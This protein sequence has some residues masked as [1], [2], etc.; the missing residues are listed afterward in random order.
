MSILCNQYT[1]FQCG[2][3][4]THVMLGTYNYGLV[5]LSYVI[6]VIGSYVALDLISSMRNESNFVFK[7]FWLIGGAL[8]MGAAIWSMHFVGMLAFMTEMKMSYGYFWTILSLFAAVVG[9]GI[10]FYMLQAKHSK[11]YFGLG[12]I[13]IGVSIV[14]MHYMGMEAMETKGSIEIFYY[15]G[16]FFLSI[17]IAIIASMGAIF[18]ALISSKGTINKRFLLKIISAIIMGIAICGMHYTGM[19]A[20]I[21]TVEQEM[22]HI[23]NNI[24]PQLLAFY[25][26]ALMSF[27]IIISLIISTQ[28]QLRLNELE[29]KKKSDY[30][31]QLKLQ[32][33]MVMQF[34][35]GAAHEINNPL[36]FILSNIGI[37]QK[38]LDIILQLQ[39]FY[40]DLIEEIKK[41]SYSF[42]SFQGIIEKI[43]AFYKSNKTAAMMH[44]SKSLM[45]ESIEGL[46]RIKDIVKNLNSFSS[47]K[48]ELKEPVEIN[49]IIGSAIDSVCEKLDNQFIVT[50]KLSSLPPFLAYPNQLKILFINLFTNAYEALEKDGEITIISFATPSEIIIKIIDNGVGISP[51]TLPKIFIPFFTTKPIGK[52][53]GLGLATVF[54]IIQLHAGST[55]SVESELGKGTT[56]IMHFPINEMVEQ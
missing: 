41:S 40:H 30:I 36:S 49:Y 45:S 34:A 27:I 17:L 21:I 29:T 4:A 31:H 8:I 18:C 43:D 53:T 42:L 26:A 52:G 51:Q 13:L 7:V 23:K 28:R 33:S 46:S 47:E 12:S 38:R 11:T 22:P 32:M 39:N 14:T 6:A 16:L 48:N 3:L 54:G 5:A 24:E 9:S 35:S 19:A 50:K 20:A 56:F 44:D 1:R 55:I 2:P 10:A 37:L 25:I 15:P